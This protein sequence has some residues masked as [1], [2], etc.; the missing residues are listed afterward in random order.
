MK[1]TQKLILLFLTAGLAVLAGQ[2]N[3]QTVDDQINVARTAL[4]ADRRATVA[5]AMQ[6]SASE[7]K[8]FWPLYEQ[9]R[10][11]MDKSGAAV[12]KLVKEYAQLYP[13]VPDERAKVMLKDLA[14][15]EQQLV[16]TRNSYLKK[17]GKVVSPAKTLRFAQ[18]ESRLDLVLR[19]GI[20]AEIPLLPIEGRLTGGGELSVVAAEGVPGGSVV[21]TYELKA[22]VASI[23]GA[24]RRI[25]L[26]DEAGIKTTVKAGP[27]VVN[28]D[29]IRVGDQLKVTTVQELVIYVAGEG[30]APTDGGV[31]LVALAPKGAKPGGIMA[32]SRQVTARVTA[33]DVEHRLATLQ[34]EDRSIRK[35]AVRQDVDL[36]KRKVGDKVVIRLTEALAIGVQKP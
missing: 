8:A 27:E 9:Y 18:V 29:Q 12:L 19:I 30:D 23:D 3:A 34:F 2:T 5:E 24:R 33:L 21:Q 4:K 7:A 28:F 6:F 22:T 25:T 13:D 35:V 20:A 11:E 26:V 16:A 15:L 10:A 14:K 1:L 32:E 31:Q 17:I 36:G